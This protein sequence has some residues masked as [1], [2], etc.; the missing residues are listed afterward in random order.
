MSEVEG[1]NTSSPVEFALS[2]ALDDLR[3]TLQFME[4]WE[5]EMPKPLLPEWE[6]MQEK[7]RESIKL[8]TEVLDGVKAKNQLNLKLSKEERRQVMSIL[9]STF[10][11][12]SYHVKT[13]DDLKELIEIA[14]VFVEAL[15]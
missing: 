9:L 6:E 14:R 8:I 2:V 13:V 3:E 7:T 12:F 11:H 5:L 1:C 10:E 15:S 4:K